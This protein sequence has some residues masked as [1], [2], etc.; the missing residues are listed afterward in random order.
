MN[1][2]K[3]WWNWDKNWLIYH[4]KINVN[5]SKDGYKHLVGLL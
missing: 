5:A 2:N 1:Y 3:D 4:M